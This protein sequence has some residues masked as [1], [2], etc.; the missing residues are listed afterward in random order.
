[1]L[2]IIDAH[3]QNYDN[4]LSANIT[5]HLQLKDEVER[6]HVKPAPAILWMTENY[7][8]P[9]IKKELWRERVAFTVNLAHRPAEKVPTNIAL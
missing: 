3:K 9:I 8:N 7:A 1:M 6:V 5:P 2:S 4:I